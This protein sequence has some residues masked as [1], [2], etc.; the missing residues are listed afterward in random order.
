MWSVESALRICRARSVLVT[1][2]DVLANHTPPLKAVGN[3]NFDTVLTKPTLYT[4]EKVAISGS[5]DQTRD[6]N[7]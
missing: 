5:Y 3:C 7:T 2:I 6:S 4:L 1:I